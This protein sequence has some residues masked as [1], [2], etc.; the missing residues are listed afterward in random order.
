MQDDKT[1]KKE[2]I[3]KYQDVLSRAGLS[4]KEAIVYEVL[5]SSGQLGVRDLTPKTPY[6]R[7]DLYNIL[8]S[9]RDKSVIEQTIKNK[10]IQFRPRDPYRLKEY[11]VDQEQKFR[12]ADSLID[13]VLPG[14]SEMFKMTT[15]RPVVRVMEGYEGIKELYEDTLKVGKPID[16]FLEA[17]ESDPKVWRWL[18]DHY[19][20]R[21]VK[22]NI[23]ARVIVSSGEDKNTADYL[24]HDKTELRETRVVKKSLFTCKLEIQIY[25]NKVSFCNYNKDDVLVAVIIDNKNIAESMRGLF[26]LAW[27]GAGG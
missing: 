18:R 25:G 11:I 13:S 14:L 27:R 15:E 17:A 26:E 5:L 7:G 9:L 16:A 1:P 2:S 8:Y 3:S 23:P 19:V 21:R 6:K 20:E 12:E 4:E 24:A 10:K 22:A